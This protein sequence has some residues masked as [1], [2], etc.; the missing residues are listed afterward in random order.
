M[1]ASW[2]EAKSEIDRLIAERIRD[3]SD[4]TIRNTED[5]LAFAADRLAPPD[6]IG[7]GYWPTMCISWSEAKPAPIEIEINAVQYEFYRMFDGRTEIKHFDHTPG[8]PIPDMLISLLA[9]APL[10]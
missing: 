3:F 8:Q 7:P 9:E 4:E 2:Q 10:S 5:F 1:F 6:E